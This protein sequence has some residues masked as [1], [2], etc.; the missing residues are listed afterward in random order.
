MSAIETFPTDPLASLVDL[1][2]W[3]SV[4]R[5]SSTA[6]HCQPNTLGLML[7]FNQIVRRLSA[8]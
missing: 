6:L 5:S 8:K 1:V 7:L 2:Q 3:T 4:F